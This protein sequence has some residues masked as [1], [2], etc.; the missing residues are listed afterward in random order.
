MKTL[1]LQKRRYHYQIVTRAYRVDYVYVDAG[2]L[3]A[4]SRKVN[5]RDY[6]VEHSTYDLVPQTVIRRRIQRVSSTPPPPE[7]DTRSGWQQAHDEMCQQFELA[8]SS[9]SEHPTPDAVHDGAEERA[10]QISEI[11]EFIL[12]SEPVETAN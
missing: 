12:K 4:A 8:C 3:S 11:C 5:R 10:D 2:N 7:K 9:S 6:V 1:T